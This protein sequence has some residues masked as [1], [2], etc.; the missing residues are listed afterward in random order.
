MSN[1][2]NE[3]VRKNGIKWVND[4]QKLNEFIVHSLPERYNS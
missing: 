2:K 4:R 1:D 3:T